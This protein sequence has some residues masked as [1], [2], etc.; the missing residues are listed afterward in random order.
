MN[1]DVFLVTPQKRISL[2]LLLSNTALY[3]T[4]VAEMLLIDSFK[5]NNLPQFNAGRY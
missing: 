5:I 3:I 4:G 2:C 1:L